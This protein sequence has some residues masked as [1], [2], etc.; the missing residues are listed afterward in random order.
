[1]HHPSHCKLDRAVQTLHSGGIIAY[2][3]EAVFGLGCDPHN[4]QTVQ[5][6]LEIKQ[7]PIHKGLILIAS[8]QQQLAPYI[9][10]PSQ[11]LQNKLNAS[12]PGPVTWLLPARPEVPEYLRGEHTTLAVRVTAHPLAAALCSAFG[13]PIVSTSA[14]PGGLAP[15]RDVLT[16]RRYFGESLDYVLNGPLGELARPTEIRHGQTGRVMRAS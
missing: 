7:R 5:R 6:L 12:W 13:G 16:V 15:A 2:P 1:M 3:T 10:P 14:N 8:D 11:A 9:Q 4:A